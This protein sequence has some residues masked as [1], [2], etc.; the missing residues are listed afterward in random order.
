[1]F[2]ND[3]IIT[4]YF[5]AVQ[6]KLCNNKLQVTSNKQQENSLNYQELDMKIAISFSLLL[7]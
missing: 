7:Q 5:N 1:M 4:W 6:R 3:E 2:R